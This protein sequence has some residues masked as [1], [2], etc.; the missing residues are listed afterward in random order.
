MEKRHAKGPSL[1]I[2]TIAGS[3][4]GGS[5]GAVI[6]EVLA[7]GSGAL[8]GM[9]SAASGTSLGASAS[10]A[11]TFLAQVAPFIGFSD[12]L[13]WLLN[14][15]SGD[16]ISSIWGSFGSSL[17]SVSAIPT[18]WMAS[19]PVSDSLLNSGSNSLNSASIG[20]LVNSIINLF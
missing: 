11:G 2:A 19:I 12:N 20:P 16:L 3:L 15:V 17:G 4:G 8:L 5:T 13:G 7:G 1:A 18:S 6:P 14:S 10:S 9:S